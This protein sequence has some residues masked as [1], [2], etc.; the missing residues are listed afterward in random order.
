MLIDAQKPS[1]CGPYAAKV[2]GSFVC[3]FWGTNVRCGGDFQEFCVGYSQAGL[4]CFGSRGKASGTLGKGYSSGGTGFVCTHVMP[5][6]GIRERSE[7]NL[8]QLIHKIDSNALVFV[9]KGF[10]RILPKNRHFLVKV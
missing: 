8:R 10:F 3:P 5:S 1:Q 2:M 4:C 6:D 7:K 9:P